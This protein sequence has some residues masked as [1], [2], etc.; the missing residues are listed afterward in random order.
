MPETVEEIR[1]N[2]KY[3]QL[4]HSEYPEGLDQPSTPKVRRSVHLTKN[5]LQ[6]ITSG[7]GGASVLPP[8][9]RYIEKLRNGHIVVIEEPPAYRT[10]S[11]GY[12]MEQEIAKLKS[13]GKIEE[14]DIDT[15]YYSD[16]NNAPFKFNLAFP[17]VIFILMFDEVNH[18]IA[19]QSYLRNARL[20]GL[21]DYLLK[22]PL[23][24]ISS[25]QHICF[26]DKAHGDFNT[27]HDAIENTIMVFWSATFN[28]DYTYNYAAYKDVPG[29][30][31]YLGWQALSQIDPM[32]IYSVDW[33]KMDKN[34]YQT[35]QHLKDQHH[36]MPM[37]HLGYKELEHLFTSPGDTGKDALPYSRSRKKIRLYYDIAQG[38]YLD[39]TFYVHVGDPIPWGKHTAYIDSFIGFTETDVI[40]E[41]RLQLDNEKLIKVKFNTKVKDFIHAGA[42]KLRY[43]EQGT[44]KNGT[45]IKEGDIIVVKDGYGNPSYRKVHFIRNARD[46]VTE[47]RIGNSFYILEN[48]EGELFNLDTPKYDNIILNK[49]ENYVIIRSVNSGPYH[50]GSNAQY[51][52]LDVREDGTLK[53]S[54]VGTDK[55]CSPQDQRYNL[56]V[57]DSSSRR[58][59][60]LGRK[61]RKLFTEDEIR[62][63]PQVFRIG[64]KLLAQ[65]D[66]RHDGVDSYCWATPGGVVYDNNHSTSSPDIKQVAEHLIKN[67][68]LTFEVES[69]DLNI[70]F[71]LGDKVVFSDWNN[72]INMLMVRTITA[73][74]IDEAKG[75]L[76][77]VLSDKDGVLTQV[78]YVKGILSS[79]GSSIISVGKIRKITN[80]FDRVTAGTKIIAQHGYIPHFPKKDVNIIIGFITDTGG[81]EPL[82]LCSNCCTLWYSDMMEKFKRVGMKSKKWATLAHA[83]I[84]I[85]KIKPQ[86]GD[87]LTGVGGDYQNSF[88]WLVIRTNESK[89]PRMMSLG[90]YTSYP[91]TYTIDNYVKN[92]TVLDCIPN[93]RISPTEQ[94]KMEATWAFPN[95]HGL[96]IENSLSQLQFLQEERSFLHVQDSCE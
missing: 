49:E 23:M 47:A 11:V 95:F 45:V 56:Q 48:T 2:P 54:F 63:L 12:P 7:F 59:A 79:R 70:R 76:N 32:F 19:G 30:S 33:I 51:T 10:I 81:D 88:G 39:S 65:T 14:W 93:P 73:F 57:R 55:S 34:I 9:C 68:G 31:T 8:N 62:P 74:T 50:A 83:P 5:Y 71:D 16:F 78:E 61:Q 80:K 40:R 28:S 77:F 90:Y 41:I 42:K 89:T 82:V 13:E 35:L 43:D 27:L 60:M 69:F 26:G 44:M 92:H 58:M 18:L 46:G 17:Y 15:K 72:P 87:I 66:M 75:T 24:N 29:V 84:D 52:G 22:A 67:D 25:N 96:F 6:K 53:F 86:P 36:N 37:T 4:L 85:T 21:S 91:E 3:V 64:R 20:A 1:I 38:I 94:S